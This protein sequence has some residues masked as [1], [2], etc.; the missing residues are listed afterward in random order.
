M[1]NNNNNGTIETWILRL[2]IDVSRG[3]QRVMDTWDTLSLR[4]FVTLKVKFNW[5]KIRPQ[6]NTLS[7]SAAPNFSCRY[8][9]WILGSVVANN[10]MFSVSCSK[11]FSRSAN[12]R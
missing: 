12:F 1:H 9:Y 11:L 3:W 8:W 6:K 7:V 10:A 4:P 2:D 5:I